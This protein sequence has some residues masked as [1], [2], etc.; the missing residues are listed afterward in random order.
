[1]P[2][3][4]LAGDTKK[5][6]A[7]LGVLLLVALALSGCAEPM[8]IAA[9]EPTAT[10]YAPPPTDLPPPSPGPTPAQLDFPLPPPNHVEMEVADDQY[11]VDCH[12]DADILRAMA[13]EEIEDETLSE[14]EG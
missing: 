13:E 7:T 2:K 8:A 4:L 1:M 6:I 10:V 12:T 5:L 11:C 14:G 3:K 9:V